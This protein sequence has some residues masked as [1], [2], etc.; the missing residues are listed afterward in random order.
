M[1]RLAQPLWSALLALTLFSG[2]SKQVKEPVP[3]LSAEFNATNAF[4]HV[5]QLVAIGPRYSGSPGIEKAKRYIE[6]QLSAAGL[7]IEFQVFDDD[8]PHGS[9]KF[10]N[11]IAYPK[12]RRGERII[13]A[14]HYDTKWIENVH[15]V[16]AND[17]GS[18]SGLLL[19]LARV[20]AAHPMQPTPYFIFFDGEESLGEWGPTNGLFGSRYLVRAWQRRG[21]L[22]QVRA[23]IL[24]DMIGD[25]TLDVGI[26]Q[27]SSAK[28]AKA[29]FEASQ[30]LG[31]RG[32]FSLNS[33]MIA[34]DHVP[35]IMAGIPSIDLIDFQFGSTP[36]LNDYWHTDQDTLDKISPQSIEIVGRT[37]LK[38]LPKAVRS[39]A[40]TPQP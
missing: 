1:L 30:E 8:T 38:A 10:S 21:E 5:E 24:A 17:G 20:L 37:I 27:N 19:E 35:F 14:S 33:S 40:T 36:G 11:I 34:D 12:W 4:R 18:S 28:L 9:R 2:C 23:M 6:A 31:Y 15:F 13:F 22:A 25:K 29:V 16:G 26:P 39:L 7:D 3:D 32:S